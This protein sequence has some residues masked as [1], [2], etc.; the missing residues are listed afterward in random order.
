[1]PGAADCTWIYLAMV[2]HNKMVG[3][4]FQN[5][6]QRSRFLAWAT[7]FLQEVRHL[8][9]KMLTSGARLGQLATRMIPRVRWQQLRQALDRA[10]E[11]DLFQEAVGVNAEMPKRS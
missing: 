10:V 8:S 9:A 4:H 2:G 1:M 6:Y 3:I 7:V 5:E 11:R